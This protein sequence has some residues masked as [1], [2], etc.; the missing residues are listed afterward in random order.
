[1]PLY[2]K[3]G[4]IDNFV[5]SPTT[6]T[7]AQA[8]KFPVDA[9]VK[10]VEITQ[11]QADTANATGFRYEASAIFRYL[12]DEGTGNFIVQPDT[13]PTVTFDPDRVKANVG[14]VVTVEITHSNAGINGEQ[15]FNLAG[16]PT[17]LTF[18]NGVVAAAPLNTE[19]P[20]EYR[21]VS[22]HSFRVIAPLYVTV[23][24][25]KIGMLK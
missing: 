5:R 4:S 15:E 2:A 6:Y 13:R 3:V 21:V 14:D 11:A 18:V 1:M 17:R 22:Q 8:D 23:F 10:I 16:I 20:G 9:P 12:W 24:Q 19:R 25:D 7:Q